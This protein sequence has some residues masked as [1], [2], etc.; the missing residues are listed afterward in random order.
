M[1]QGGSKMKTESNG[2]TKTKRVNIVT[3]NISDIVNSAKDLE[4]MARFAG[5]LKQDDSKIIIMNAMKSLIKEQKENIN[6]LISE[7]KQL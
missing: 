1:V 2:T 5:T 7:L 3:E 4:K 6:S